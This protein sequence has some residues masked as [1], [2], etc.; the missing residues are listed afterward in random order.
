MALINIHIVTISVFAGLDW[1]ALHHVM[2]T[3]LFY[4]TPGGIMERAFYGQVRRHARS[5]R[6]F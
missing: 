5:V 3:K 6:L 2:K 1:C 4:L